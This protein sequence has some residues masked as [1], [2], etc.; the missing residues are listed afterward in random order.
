MTNQQ[1]FQQQCCRLYKKIIRQIA[2]YESKATDEKK[3][4]E[5]GFSITTKAWLHIQETVEGY[6]FTDQQ[7]E[8]GFYKTLKPRFIALMDFFTLLY[9]SVLFQPEDAAG[10]KEYW[11][12]E[13]TTCKMFLLKHKTFCRY[14]EQ[15][16]T[17]MDHVYFVQ[18]NNQQ[19]LL[20]GISENKGPV[21]PSYSY[22]L[23]RII[24]MQ[25]Y[26]HYVLKKLN[27]KTAGFELSSH[28]KRIMRVIF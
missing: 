1:C 4:I 13:L 12:S 27:V 15:G 14:Y 10:K 17:G 20:F 8:I 24:S 11:K 5:W 6:S 2:C 25:K 16:N 22:L 21:I 18:Q 26:Q 7:E 28:H 3:W 23:A 9:R 19:S